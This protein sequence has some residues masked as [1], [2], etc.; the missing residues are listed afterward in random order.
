[1]EVLVKFMLALLVNCRFH[2]LFHRFFLCP[3]IGW[4]MTDF[5]FLCSSPAGR[6]APCS[7]FKQSG[8]FRCCKLTLSLDLKFISLSFSLKC[9]SFLPFLE[10]HKCGV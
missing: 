2:A 10:S 6:N 1:M 8:T 7:P 5:T 3:F 9:A 4:I